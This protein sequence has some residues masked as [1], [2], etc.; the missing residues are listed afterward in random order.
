[1]Y[2]SDCEI[3]DNL[4]RVIDYADGGGMYCWNSELYMQ[5]CI[6]SSNESNGSAGGLSCWRNNTA[7]LNRCIIADNWAHG[8]D[9]E[10]IGGGI[11]GGSTMYNCVISGNRADVGAGISG[12]G[13]T[14]I[15]CTVSGNAGTGIYCLDTSIITNCIIWGNSG[16]EITNTGTLSVTYSDIE[17][18]WDGVG[19]IDVNPL[20]LGGGD[21]HLTVDSPCI[22][23]GTDAGVYEDIDGDLRPQGDGFDMGADENTGPIPMQA[24]K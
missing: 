2:M 12:S 5:D 10:S 21:Y 4:S 3:S 9:W 6:I 11:W 7:V 16:Y 1:M 23:V 22:D 8:Y 20:F 14:L 17:G 24:M 15:N 19:N 18:G 13:P